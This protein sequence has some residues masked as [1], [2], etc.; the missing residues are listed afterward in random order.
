MNALRTHPFFAPIN[1]SRLWTD[2]VP[3]LEPGLVKK[4][5]HPLHGGSSSQ[6]WEDVGAAW[7]ELV[8]QD[9]DGDG[10]SWASDGEGGELILPPGARVPNGYF[11]QEV[12]AAVGP[13]GEHRPYAG[14]GP[15]LGQVRELPESSQ[16]PL[17][18]NRDEPPIQFPGVPQAGE[19][20]RG[21]Q[22]GESNGA[23]AGVSVR[24]SASVNVP[25]AMQTQP[26]DVP[27]V[28]IADS[29]SVSAGSAGSASSS[30]EGSPIGRLDAAMAEAAL[31]RGRTRAQTPIQ[32][33]YGSGDPEWY[34]RRS[35]F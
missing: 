24:A 19:E 32:D 22:Q 26:I 3:P 11:A 1:W 18:E 2:E 7:D 28:A 10:L 9:E 35:Q 15:A 14:H 8:G 4:E 13:L 20:L 16:Q 12:V 27:Q 34:F 23:G 17:H 25:A 21:A 31:S 29:H 5:L 30:S 33:G 6:N